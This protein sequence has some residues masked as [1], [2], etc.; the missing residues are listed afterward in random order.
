MKDITD[1]LW[2]IVF[3]AVAI[4]FA[5]YFLNIWTFPLFEGWWTLF[6]IVPS[7]IALTKKEGRAGGLFGL[8]LGVLLLLSSNDIID[9]SSIWKIIIVVILLVIGLKLIFS[10]GNMPELAEDNKD[11]TA[12]FSESNVYY[13]ENQE[14]N[15]CNSKAIF[16]SVGID[17]RDAKISSDGKINAVSI[18][19]GTDIHVPRNVNLEVDS[20]GIFGGVKNYTSNKESDNEF[21]IYINAIAIFGGVDIK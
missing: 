19:G 12:I 1:L 3:I 6:I 5:L 10:R 21:T 4:I 18:F 13:N 11:V 2:G 15:D 14:F 20:T 8:I 9:F 17:L 7:L 16:G